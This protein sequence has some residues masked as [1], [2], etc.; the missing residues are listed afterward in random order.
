VH[1]S[2]ISVDKLNHYI[3]NSLQKQAG[4]SAPLCILPNGIQANFAQYCNPLP[5]EIRRSKNKVVPT[6]RRHM[7][8]GGIAQL[9]LILHTSVV[10]FTP[11]PFCPRGGKVINWRFR[12]PLIQ[13]GC[14]GGEKNVLHPWEIEPQF[15]ERPEVHLP[16]DSKLIACHSAYIVSL[17]KTNW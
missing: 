2:I 4:I 17:A 12:G 9:I 11:R 10:S 5:P 8:S 16:Y 6:L 7:Y 1:V 14:F 15:L 3:L 13:C